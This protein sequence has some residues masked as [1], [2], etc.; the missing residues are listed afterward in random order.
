M[1]AHVQKWRAEHANYRKLLDLL[2]ALIANFV[3]GDELDYDLMADIVYYM[4][5]YPDHY[6]HPREDEAFGR[7]LAHDP[8]ARPLI[9]HLTGEHRSIAESSARLATDLAA[10]AAGT[11]M[12]RATLQA[13]VHDYV[14]F[15]KDHMDTEER[16]IFPRLDASLSDDDW[17][18][19]DSAIHFAS[20]PI[21]GDTVQERFRSIHRHIA[22]QVH[23][24]CEEPAE[25]AC[26]LD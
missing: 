12:P 18:L 8:Q 11:M 2:E 23:C 4:T 10:A 22:G 13:D 14:V 1:T 21:F 16:E 19:V 26:C 25:A 7:L 20:D 6:H 9:E 17:F 5:Q 3:D 15:L 24:G